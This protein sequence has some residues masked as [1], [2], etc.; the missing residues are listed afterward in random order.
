MEYV[1]FLL[2]S[3]Q[4]IFSVA[5]L[6]LAHSMVLLALFCF[7][8]MLFRGDLTT[9]TWFFRKDLLHSLILSYFVFS[10][11]FIN[12][13]WA[14]INRTEEFE[15]HLF[16]RFNLLVSLVTFSG[17]FH[18]F[19]RQ[20]LQKKE[21]FRYYRFSTF[22]LSNIARFILVARILSFGLLLSIQVCLK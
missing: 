11:E 22:W 19:V 8:L 16:Q 12:R 5:L 9:K 10:L 21:H 17:D 7:P 1:S 15:I 3:I 18:C 13:I 4:N 6:K 2:T 14:H 20:L